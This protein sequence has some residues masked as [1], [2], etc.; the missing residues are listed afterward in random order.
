MHEYPL[1]GIISVFFNDKAMLKKTMDSVLAQTYTNIEHI[2]VDGGSKDGS[3]DLLREYESKYNGRLKWISEPDK[4]I[5]DAWNKA[6]SMSTGEL[7]LAHCTDTLFEQTVSKMV[8]AI[9]KSDS[10]GCYGGMLYLKDN[11]IIRKWGWKKGHLA[12]GWMPATPTLCIKRGA[13]TKYGGRI[14]ETYKGAGDYEH[15]LRILKDG[16]VRLTSIPEYLI[17]YTPGGLSN[18]GIKEFTLGIRERYRALRANNYPCAWFADFCAIVRTLSSYIF[19][20]RKEYK[21]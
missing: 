15:I 18:G 9:Q 20:L 6:F 2:V 21:I 10:D 11:K 17:A 4:G 14:I 12:L 8:T 7:I 16:T 3:A 1:V 5:D 13:I 19:V